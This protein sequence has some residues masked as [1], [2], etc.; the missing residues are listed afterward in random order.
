[1]SPVAAASEG[2]RLALERF[3]ELLRS[4]GVRLGLISESDQGRIRERHI[5]DSLRALSCIGAGDRD[6]VDLGSGAGL[7]GI[8][9]A[10]AAPDR[11][12]TLVESLRRRGA[13]LE[14]AVQELAL[15]N[16]SVVVGR[17]EDLVIEADVCMARAFAPPLA[18]WAI[19][20]RLLRPTGRLVYFAGMSWAATEAAV[21]SEARRRGVVVEICSPK[22]FNW[23]GPLVM[24]GRLSAR[25][26]SQ[27]HGRKPR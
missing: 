7:P 24:M 21:A 19:A 12:F 2:Q 10:V 3:E 20:Q 11:R 18:S 27:G 8:P 22:R 26:G 14:L 9:L 25:H 1:L 23:Q 17:A 16:V 5:E 4:R 6:V 15:A 13:F